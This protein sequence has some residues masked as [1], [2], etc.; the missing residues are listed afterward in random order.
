MESGIQNINMVG[1]NLQNIA[2]TQNDDDS[3]NN[4][5]SLLYILCVV[6]MTLMRVLTDAHDVFVALV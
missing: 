3:Q 6:I 2:T 1:N 5:V 4:M